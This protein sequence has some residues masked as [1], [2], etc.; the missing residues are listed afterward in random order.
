MR[1]VVVVVAL[2]LPVFLLIAGCASQEKAGD[3]AQL[4]TRYSV[5]HGRYL[6]IDDPYWQQSETEGSEAR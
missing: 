1:R 3:E 5:E 4:N 2:L 6:P